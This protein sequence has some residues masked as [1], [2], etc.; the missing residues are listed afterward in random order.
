MK[1]CFFTF[2]ETMSIESNVNKRDIEIIK[3]EELKREKQIQLKGIELSLL[4]FWA[5]NIKLRSLLFLYTL[6]LTPSARLVESIIGLS[7]LGKRKR[8]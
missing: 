2:I 6:Y 4:T 1:I 8:R 5:F 3:E 7:Y